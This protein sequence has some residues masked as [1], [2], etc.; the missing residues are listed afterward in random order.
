MSQDEAH[1]PQRRERAPR[2]HERYTRVDKYAQRYERCASARYARDSAQM[3]EKR[4]RKRCRKEARDAV[5]R[6]VCALCACRLHMRCARYVCARYARAQRCV[7]FFF[8]LF[9]ILFD[10]LFPLMPPPCRHIIRYSLL[11]CCRCLPLPRHA[12]LRPTR[13][14]HLPLACCHLILFHIDYAF[15]ITTPSPR[16]PPPP[17]AIVCHLHLPLLF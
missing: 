14:C 10:V 8:C 5:R 6:A 7:F 16:S 3:R 12:M 2:H 9:L 15:H 11:V 13:R 17:Y 1:R 4:A